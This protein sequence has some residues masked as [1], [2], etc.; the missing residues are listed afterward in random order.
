MSPD[1]NKLSIKDL[2]IRSYIRSLLNAGYDHRTIV[3]RA[4][5]REYAKAIDM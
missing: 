2:L 3:D 1:I 5:A 4:R